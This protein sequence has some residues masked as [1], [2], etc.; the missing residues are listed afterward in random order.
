MAAQYRSA[1]EQLDTR[2]GEQTNQEDQGGGTGEQRK[3]RAPRWPYGSDRSGG[4]NARS[5]S[6]GGNHLGHVG[7]KHLGHLGGP[8]VGQPHPGH[9]D[10]AGAVE[11]PFVRHGR[12]CRDHRSDSR[13]DDGA[14]RAEDGSRDSARGRRTGSGND[15]ADG[16]ACLRRGGRTDGGGEGGAFRNDEGMTPPLSGRRAGQR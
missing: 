11:R 4:A 12:H 8:A 16:Q 3:S 10:L 2:H 13:P 7:G 9:H 15:L 1:R 5:R 6:L 14:V